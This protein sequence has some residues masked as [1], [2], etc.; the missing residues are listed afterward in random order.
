MAYKLPAYIYTTEQLFFEKDYIFFYSQSDGFTMR[1]LSVDLIINSAYVY[2]LKFRSGEM[3]E[4]TNKPFSLF[5]SG[6]TP[7]PIKEKLEFLHSLKNLEKEISSS[8][9]RFMDDVGYCGI[10]IKNNKSIVETSISIINFDK[11]TSNEAPIAQKELIEM[12]R[13]INDWVERIYKKYQNT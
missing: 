3:Q 6:D 13:L 11:L 4:S 7:I 12:Y 8:Y 10:I 1:H 5:M 9:G 2:E